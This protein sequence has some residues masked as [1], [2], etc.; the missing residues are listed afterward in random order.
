MKIKLK[1]RYKYEFENVTIKPIDC[2]WYS[3]VG[4]FSELR[5]RRFQPHCLALEE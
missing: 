1:V 4:A 2:F 5:H 3:R